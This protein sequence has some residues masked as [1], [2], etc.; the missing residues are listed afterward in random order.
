MRSLKQSEEG[1]NKIAAL[2]LTFVAIY[3]YALL[4]PTVKVFILIGVPWMDEVT[5]TI[6]SIVPLGIFIGIIWAGAMLINTP[7]R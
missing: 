4:E 2:I 5:A 3:I 7:T 6:F 1:D